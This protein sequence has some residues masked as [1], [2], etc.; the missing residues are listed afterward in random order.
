M[1]DADLK[2]QFEKIADTARTATDKV[3]AAGQ[4]TRDQLE[5]DVATAHERAT[6]AA[7]RMK[8]KADA[9]GDDASSDWQEIREKWHAHVAKVQARAHKKKDQIDAHNA[10][11][12]ADMTEAYAY[13]AIDFA[14]DAIEEAEYSVLDALY[15]RAN[16]ESLKAGGGGSF[17]CG[18]AIDG[19]PRTRDRLFSVLD[20]RQR[21][22]E[23]RT[24]IAHLVSDVLSLQSA[25]P[26]DTQNR[27]S[28][29]REVVAPVEWS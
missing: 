4:R 18:S 22:I 27:R 7:D 8:D 14:L 15:A 13:D 11:M 3:E 29:H 21:I 24:D 26:I 5:A 12:D 25:K 17:L 19:R 23:P 1:S 9:A 6:A 20:L 2:A 16:A 28:H 10:A